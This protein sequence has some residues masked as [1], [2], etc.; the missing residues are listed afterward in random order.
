MLK[1]DTLARAAAPHSQPASLAQKVGRGLWIVVAV[2]FAL[3]GSLVGLLLLRSPGK[4]EPF[5]DENGR[6]L[7][8]SL[9]EKIHVNINGVEQGMFIQSKDVRNPVLLFV[10]GG[11]GMP[12]YFLTERYPTGLEQVFTV[13]WWDQRGTG[14]S[15]QPDLPRETMT[16]EQMIADTLEVTNYLRNRFGQ[17]KIY[18]MGHSWGTFIGIQAAAQ[19]PQLYHAYIGMAQLTYQL[20]SEQLAYEY[21]LKQCQANGNTRLLRK[22]EAAPF[23]TTVP[24]PPAYDPLRDEAMHSLGVGTTHDMRS[25]EMGV[26]VPSWLSRQ[27]TLPEK[28][29]L[30]RGKFWSKGILWNEVLATDLTEKVTRLDIPVY[31]FQGSYDYT[32]NYSLA[33]AYLE[34]LQAPLKG[35]YTFE[36]SAHSPVLEEPERALRIL[37]EDVL[38]GKNSLADVR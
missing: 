30:W 31:V 23:P 6:P 4:P 18:L 16:V 29:A 12:T 7:L 33:R 38:G 27:Y 19:A 13:V 22:L 1:Q 37:R 21:M 20:K 35:F 5:L 3:L 32:A 10:H 25:V 8:G 9:S 28:V 17:D 14:L 15:Y 36:Q 34:Q 24:L 11:P 26:F 2:V